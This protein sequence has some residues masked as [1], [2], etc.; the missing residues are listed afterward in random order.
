MTYVISTCMTPACVRPKVLLVIFNLHYV[1]LHPNYILLILK[2]A[3]TESCWPIVGV[4]LEDVITCE[5]TPF[6][7]AMYDPN[8]A[9]L[10]D[11]KLRI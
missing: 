2:R 1:A 7:F 5:R 10:Q 6:N 3:F 9:N 8:L 4:L 11:S